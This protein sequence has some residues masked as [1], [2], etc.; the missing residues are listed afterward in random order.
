MAPYVPLIAFT[1]LDSFS[2]SCFPETL[3]NEVSLASFAS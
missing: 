2:F 1:Q 3:E